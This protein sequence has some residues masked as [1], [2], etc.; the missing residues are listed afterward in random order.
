MT[1]QQTIDSAVKE[2]EQSFAGNELNWQ[3]CE[4]GKRRWINNEH[5]KLFII[6]SIKKAVE[7]AYK[8]LAE[9]MKNGMCLNADNGLLAFRKETWNDAM[10]HALSLIEKKKSL[11]LNKNI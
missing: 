11:F 4:C 6:S 1:L 8:D 5:I 3:T 10:M 2:F 7:V 9:E